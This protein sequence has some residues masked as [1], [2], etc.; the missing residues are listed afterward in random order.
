MII[1]GFDTAEAGLRCGEIMAEVSMTL[2]HL[3]LEIGE[4][5]LPRLGRSGTRA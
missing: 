4:R 3:G 2:R 5:A 1:R